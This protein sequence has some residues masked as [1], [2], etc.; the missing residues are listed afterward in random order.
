MKE[1]HKEKFLEVELLNQSM[2]TCKEF[3]ICCQIALQEKHSNLHFHKHCISDKHSF[4]PLRRLDSIF[5]L[6]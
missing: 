1:K 3:G 6:F 2:H 4:S 5:S